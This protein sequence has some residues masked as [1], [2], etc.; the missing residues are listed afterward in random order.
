[1]HLLKS[2]SNHRY[3]QYDP[4]WQGTDEQHLYTKNL[5]TQPKDWKYA[6]ADVNY[7]MNSDGFR[8]SEFNSIEW[9]NSVVWV[10]CS[11]TFGTGV[12]DA[13]TVTEYFSQLSGLPVVNLGQQGVGID[14]IVDTLNHLHLSGIKPKHIVIQFPHTSRTLRFRNPE[15]FENL[16]V[17][18]PFKD[19]QKY[20]F[21]YKYHQT[22]YNLM[23]K[24]MVDVAYPD[25]VCYTTHSYVADALDVWDLD[26]GKLRVGDYA[27]DLSHPGAVYH[28]AVAQQIYQRYFA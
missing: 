17:H 27:R 2:T 24:R 23:F 20:F 1:M 8:C 22:G 14:Y 4:K 16:S 9:N 12:D 11:I 3:G 15:K 21:I 5:K 13:E 10:G 7:T 6:T 28:Q 19:F 26:P 25:A 18:S